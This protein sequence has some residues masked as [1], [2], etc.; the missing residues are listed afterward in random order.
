MK[1][2]SASRRAFL[3]A[4]AC[5]CRLKG[6]EDA[7]KSLGYTVGEEDGSDQRK[8]AA[9]DHIPNDIIFCIKTLMGGKA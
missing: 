6:S 2:N 1:K 7:L 9:S 8:Q 3:T 4:R 5:S